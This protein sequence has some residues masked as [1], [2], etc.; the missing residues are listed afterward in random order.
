MKQSTKIIST[1]FLAL[2]SAMPLGASAQ[3]PVGRD[4]A[5]NCFQCHGTDGRAEKGMPSIAGKDADSLFKKT[6]EYKRSDKLNDIMVRQAKGFTDAQIN[7]I[8]E[9]FASVPEHLDTQPVDED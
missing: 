8:A 4:L 9:Y 2:S 6:R 5:A 1:A 7:Q 3:P